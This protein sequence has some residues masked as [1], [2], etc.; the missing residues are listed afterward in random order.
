[1]D[2]NQPFVFFDVQIGEEAVGR[3]VFRLFVDVCPRTCENFRALCTGEK[4]TGAQSGKQLHYKGSWLHRVIRGFIA[5]GGDFTNYDGTGGE[6]IYGGTFADESFSLKHSRAGLLSM[7]NRGPGTNASQFF[8]TFAPAKHLD[9]KHVVFGELV[10]GKTTLKRIETCRTDAA[11]KPLTPVQI[12]DSGQLAADYSPSIEFES[13]AKDGGAAR[14]AEPAYIAHLQKLQQ[15]GVKKKK[16]SKF[17]KRKRKIKDTHHNSSSSAPPR[18]KP[19]PDSS[20]GPSGNGNVLDRISVQSV[21]DAK[22]HFDV[23]G[24]DPP[25]VA[26]NGQAEWLYT[27]KAVKTRFRKLSLKVHPDHCADPLAADAFHRV[28]EAHTVLSDVATRDT[29]MRQ[30]MDANRSRMSAGGGR[31]VSSR[32]AALEAERVSDFNQAVLNKI[33]ERLRPNRTSAPQQRIST[34]SSSDSEGSSGSGG[35]EVR[36]RTK[37][38]RGAQR[39]SV[40]F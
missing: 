14:G 2:S 40:F 3:L 36:C 39:R 26:T 15:G 25:R 4:G 12:T 30:Y 6:S 11:D 8:I 20:S 33:A 31:A 9:G 18:K 37:Q 22:N 7:A 34:P 1:M 24:L 28:R 5:Q 29:Y 17:K 19:A 16:K 35:S 32:K 38:R 10:E 27:T 23:L 21:L 13:K